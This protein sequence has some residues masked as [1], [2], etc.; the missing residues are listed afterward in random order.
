MLALLPKDRQHWGQA[1][2]AEQAEIDNSDELLGWA[3]GGVAMSVREFLGSVFDNQL[4]WVLG[5][6]LGLGAALLDLRSATRWPYL[7]AVCGIALLLALLWPRWAWRW[8]ALAAL[9]L[10]TFVLIS[11]E[12]GPYKTDQFD[13]FY[14]VLPAG[15]GTLLGLGLRKAARFRRSTRASRTAAL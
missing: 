2:I 11:S 5:S 1:L 12:W 9:V 3:A 7:I 4:G 13:V 14:G 10:P 15:L 6:V 8:T